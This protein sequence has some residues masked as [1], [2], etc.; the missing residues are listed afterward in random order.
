[1]RARR[2]V[3][4][5]GSSPAVPE[6]PGLDSGVYLTN[7]TIFDLRERPEHLI[8]I[9]AGC[10]G[11]EMAQA[12]RRLG[13]SVTVLE[14]ALPL[15]NDDP[16]C[17]AILVDCLE[18]EGIVIR[19]GVNVIGIVR[20]DRVVTAIDRAAGAEQT[21][22]GAIC[23]LPPGEGRP[24][25]VSISTLRGSADRSGIAVDR[26]LQPPTVE[27]TRSEIARLVMQRLRTRPIIMLAW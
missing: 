4:A 27:S 1:M 19:S 10:V 23:W 21:I 16:E 25:T 24:S 8:I 5:T 6:I 26:K 14:A 17:V 12:F 7:E 11:L 15:A 2:F 9:G 18:R 20:A 22:T 3:I 13:S